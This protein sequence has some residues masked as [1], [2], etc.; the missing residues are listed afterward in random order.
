MGI[1]TICKDILA[2]GGLLFGELSVRQ[3]CVE[4]PDRSGVLAQCRRVVCGNLLR[5]QV[6]IRRRQTGA[7]CGEQAELL[8]GNIVFLTG[9]LQFILEHAFDFVQ[10]GIIRRRG[11]PSSASTGGGMKPASAM[12]CRTFSCWFQSARKCDRFRSISA[13]ISEVFWPLKYRAHRAAS[14]LTIS[15]IWRSV[16]ERNRFNASKSATLVMLLFRPLKHKR[17]ASRYTLPAKL[18]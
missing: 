18:R 12:S 16:C 3:E 9:G 6:T 1:V 10:D 14:S 11:K 5:A 15:R 7:L 13:T 17:A 2:S 4:A 8:A